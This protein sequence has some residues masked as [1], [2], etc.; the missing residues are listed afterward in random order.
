MDDNNIILFIFENYVKASYFYF[1]KISWTL[2]T[3]PFM[4]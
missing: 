1:G 3:M 4:P 2:D